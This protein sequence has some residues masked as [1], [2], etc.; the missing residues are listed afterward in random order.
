LIKELKNRVV[1][2]LF[3]IK[4]CA[5]SKNGEVANSKFKDLPQ[6]EFNR[7]L[8]LHNQRLTILHPLLHG[9]GDSTHGI[10]KR[11]Q[12]LEEWIKS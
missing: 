7:F 3:V 8:F 11:F 9:A 1:H 2:R 12:E 5:S 10:L 4:F 6:L